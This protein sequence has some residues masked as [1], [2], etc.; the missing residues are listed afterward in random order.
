MGSAK[1]DHVQRIK[2]ELELGLEGREIAVRSLADPG[3]RFSA[4]LAGGI[5]ENA[6]MKAHV[7]ANPTHV[8]QTL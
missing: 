5:R 1:Y 2:H 3:L 4:S 8:S 7:A 6:R